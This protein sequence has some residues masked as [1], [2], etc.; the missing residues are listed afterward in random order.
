MSVF[1]FLSG[2]SSPVFTRSEEESLASGLTVARMSLSVGSSMS[3][4]Q[5]ANAFAESGADIAILRF[6]SQMTWIPHQLT[7]QRLKSWQ[8][9]TLIYFVREVDTSTVASTE[10]T[11]RSP[12]SHVEVCDLVERIFVDYQN[13]YKATPALGSIDIVAAYTDWSLRHLNSPDSHVYVAVDES[14]PW[15]LAVTTSDGAGSTEILLA[16]VIPRKRGRGLYSAMLSTVLKHAAREG[17]Q[18]M[19]ISTQTTN[20]RAMRTWCRLLFLP[21]I[22]LSTV[23]LQALRQ[24]S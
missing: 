21:E 7:Q 22:S 5:I 15:G 19:Y 4:E 18:R 23:H 13:H 17:C 6:P 1:Q 20:T 14:S 3:G 2:Q 24:S 8:V 10:I 12:R 11:L 16:G 9:D